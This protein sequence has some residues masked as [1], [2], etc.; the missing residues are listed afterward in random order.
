MARVASYMI[1]FRE[2]IVQSI[3]NRCRTELLLLAY[4]KRGASRGKVEKAR[5]D[6][7][8]LAFDTDSSGMFSMMDR[9]VELGALRF[10]LDDHELA[11]FQMLINCGV[12]IAVEVQ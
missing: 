1:I 7:T 11:T 6:V 8:F 4:D 5:T 12:P 2:N 3:I 10:W 9:S